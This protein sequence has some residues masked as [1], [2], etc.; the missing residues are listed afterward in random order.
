M[1]HVQHAKLSENNNKANLS[2]AELE[3]GLSLAITPVDPIE[4]VE[5][6]EEHVKLLEHLE[7]TFKNL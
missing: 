5:P 1:L 2:P 3:L 6:A 4:S 7:Q